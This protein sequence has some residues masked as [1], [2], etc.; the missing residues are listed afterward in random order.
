MSNSTRV[1]VRRPV[2]AMV[3]VAAIVA[4]L[5]A[6]INFLSTS[7]AAASGVNVEATASSTSASS[8]N[9]PSATASATST[10]TTPAF[11]KVQG[12]MR[13]PNKVRYHIFWK[14]GVVAFWTESDR[15]VASVIWGSES[16]ALPGVGLNI[17]STATKAKR[18]RFQKCGIKTH[19]TVYGFEATKYHVLPAWPCKY[20]TK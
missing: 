17:Y 2:L 18:V 11:P 13:Q 4:L 10:P 6:G 7:G 9:S 5:V 12:W 14:K 8:S 1:T 15:N 16:K 3:A 20:A 19:V